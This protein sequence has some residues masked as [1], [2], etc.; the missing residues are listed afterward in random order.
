[1]TES[2]KQASPLASSA[3]AAGSQ[4][5]VAATEKTRA[6]ENQQQCSRLVG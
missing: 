2:L 4:R 6:R 5:V 1:M 3:W